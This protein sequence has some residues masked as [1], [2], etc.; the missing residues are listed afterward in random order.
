MWVCFIDVNGVVFSFQKVCHRGSSHAINETLLQPWV[1]MVK[2]RAFLRYWGPLCGYAGLIFYLSSQPHPEEKLGTFIKL[3]SDKVLHGVEYA[4]FAALCYRAIQGGGPA[5][6][7]PYAIPSAI[8][9]ASLYGV[10]DEI[11][12][13]FVPFRD[14]SVYDWVADTVGAVLGAM[15]MHRFLSQWLIKSQPEVLRE[16]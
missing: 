4:V 7:R 6:W 8:L 15:I 10:S 13:A 14:S 1:E 5:S 3:F 9:L 16:P 11:H 12:Q 2:I